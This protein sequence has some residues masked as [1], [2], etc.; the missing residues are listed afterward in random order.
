MAY[1]LKPGQGSAFR[2]TY[3]ERGDNKP[4]FTGTF[5]S[6]EGKKMEIAMWEK[7]TGRG[8]FYSIKVKE[9][10]QRAEPRSETPRYAEPDPIGDNSDLPF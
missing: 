4:D 8:V 2:N 1:E 10:E 6:P 3:K 7:D 5:L 9:L